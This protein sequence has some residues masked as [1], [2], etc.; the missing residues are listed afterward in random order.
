MTDKINCIVKLDK[1][2]NSV[3]L[4]F[5][6]EFHTK[7]TRIPCWKENKGRFEAHYQ[8]YRND[9]RK[10][11]DSNFCDVMAANTALDRYERLHRC[12]LRLVHKIHWKQ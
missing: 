1:K 12:K 2:D 5:P 11:R 9:C 10:V 7:N 8:Y 6:D 4:F 3:L